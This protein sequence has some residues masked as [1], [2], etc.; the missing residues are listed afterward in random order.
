MTTRLP[1]DTSP[2][3]KEETA[4]CMRWD[5]CSHHHRAQ[6]LGP[7]LKRSELLFNKAKK[8]N[9]SL[10]V[11]ESR[12]W[13]LQGRTAWDAILE[14]R[15]VWENWLICKDHLLQTQERPILTS[16]TGSKGS[17]KPAWMNTELLTQLKDTKEEFKRYKRSRVTQ[18]DQR[19]AG[20]ESVKSKPVWSFIWWG[21]R[22][23][24]TG[25]PGARGKCGPA[26]K[27]GRGH[28]EK[29]QVTPCL[30]HLSLYW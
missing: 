14:K 5:C 21:K 20:I 23:A 25:A 24:S 17:R 1:A 19:D 22:R 15:G 29:G 13:S 6:T 16:R 27:W 28:N 18:E 9:H 3:R 8:Q 7:L 10:G 26:D 12:V 30:L 4:V 2:S 11:Q